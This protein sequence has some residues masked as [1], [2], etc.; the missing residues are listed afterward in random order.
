MRVLEG[1]RKAGGLYPLSQPGLL[2][3]RGWCNLR[4]GGGLTVPERRIR[5]EPG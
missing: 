2:L 5:W 4:K 1:K 3:A